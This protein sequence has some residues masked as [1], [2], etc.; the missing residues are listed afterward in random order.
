MSYLIKKVSSYTY[1]LHPF[2]LQRA[3]KLVQNH[4][5]QLKVKIAQKVIKRDIYWYE[6]TE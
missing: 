5:S 1:V 4:T 3:N 6:K 2:T